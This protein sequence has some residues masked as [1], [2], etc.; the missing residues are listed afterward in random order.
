M[1]DAI[2]LV[3]EQDEQI[4]LMPKLEAHEKGLLHRAF[5]VFLFNTQGQ[6]LLQQRAFG[7]YHSEG[8]WSN[9]CCSHPMPEE[10]IHSSA[11][12]RLM[13][14]MGLKTDLR[15]LYSFLYKAALDKGL[16]EHEIDHIF[17]GTTDELPDINTDEVSAWKYISIDELLTD[18]ELQPELYT[19]WFK[20]EVKNVLDKIKQSI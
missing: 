16:T 19:I 9:T 13:E 12:R 17:V 18:I 8:L 2:I 1:K 6:L 15:F 4:G 3:N 5:S 7:K 20:M 14:E 10:E 11:H